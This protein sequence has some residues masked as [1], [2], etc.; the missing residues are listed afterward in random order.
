MSIRL[1]VILVVSAVIICGATAARA[2]SKNLVPD[3]GF[4]KADFA[5]LVDKTTWRWHPIAAPS[6]AA[7]DKAKKE[8]KLTGGKTF[9]HS[10]VFDVTPGH[11][12]E[13]K[14][15]AEGAGKVSIQ[16]L[17]WTVYKG[18]DIGMASPHCTM[19]QNP[20]ALDNEAKTF[21]VL[22]GAPKDATRA[23]IRVIVEEGAVTISEPSVTPSAEK[24]EP[25]VIPKPEEEK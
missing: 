2:A 3:P 9:L 5:P 13:I 16:C 8:V 10:P 22:D 4:Q 14:V 21:D 7:L 24:V 23:Y 18:D 20:V 25:K 12:Y 17:W 19:P 11:A 6:E 1:A 15:K